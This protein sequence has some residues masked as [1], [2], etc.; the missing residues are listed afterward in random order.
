MSQDPRT[1]TLHGTPAPVRNPS[2]YTVPCELVKET[3]KALL[4]K[5]LTV[6]PPDGVEETACWFPKSQVEFNDVDMV[7]T[8]PA[9]L[10]NQKNMVSKVED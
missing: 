4:L 1:V 3:E 9:W 7:V 6:S 5:V 10:F 2:S 8:V